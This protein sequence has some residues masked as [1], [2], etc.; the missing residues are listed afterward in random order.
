MN[1]KILGAD[2]NISLV[3]NLSDNNAGE[4]DFVEKTI[5]IVNDK[6]EDLEQ[7]LRHEIMHAFFYECGLMKYAEDE[8]LV[9]F[10]AMQFDKLKH[11]MGAISERGKH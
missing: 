3:E 8:V 4:T 9:D 5:R 11:L 2:Y 1:L 6:D 10:L 7:I